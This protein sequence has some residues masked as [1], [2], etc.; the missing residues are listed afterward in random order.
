MFVGKDWGGEQGAVAP[1]V[2]FW[3]L[4]L[5]AQSRWGYA[6]WISS[7]SEEGE[8]MVSWWGVQS[9]SSGVWRRIQLVGWCV[10]RSGDL[11]A[12]D[13]ASDPSSVPLG[14]T[15]PSPIRSQ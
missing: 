13:L 8:R 1:L 15:L 10:V 14:A 5:S 6:G 7:G 11:G 4:G 3:F 12:S 2:P 9:L